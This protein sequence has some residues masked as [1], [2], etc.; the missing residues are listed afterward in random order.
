MIDSRFDGV[1][2]RVSGGCSIQKG[3]T[4]TTELLEAETSPAA[5]TLPLDAPDVSAQAD[6]ETLRAASSASPAL[7]KQ[8]AEVPA[9]GS[10]LMMLILLAAGG[11]FAGMICCSLFA[12]LLCLV[13]VADVCLLILVMK[14]GL[15]GPVIDALS[16]HTQILYAFGCSLRGSKGA[17]YRMLLQRTDAPRLFEA[18]ENLCEKAS[19]RFPQAVYL[20]SG[21]NAWVDSAGL[22]RKNR[23]TRL[24][25]GLDLL[26]G[27]SEPETVA[28]LAHE[29]AHAQRVQWGL[30]HLTC[31][32][33]S[34]IAVLAAHLM[35]L[36]IELR[37]DG[38]RS[39]V[40]CYAFRMTNHL[41]CLT[42]RLLA[43]S[44]RQD[45]YEADR[46]A[47]EMAGLVH[48]RSGL[49]KLRVV[50]SNSCRL[51]W[52]ERL[53]RLETPSGFTPWLIGQLRTDAPA[54][55]INRPEE[56]IDPYATHP[57]NQSRLDALPE[58]LEIPSLDDSL[59]LNLLN[60]PEDLANRLA[61]EFRRIAEKEELRDTKGMPRV[62]YQL[63]RSGAIGKLRAI[64]IVLLSMGI[65]G[66][67][68]MAWMSAFTAG[69][70]FITIGL[71]LTGAVM[72][73]SESSEDVLQLR[74]PSFEALCK[75]KPL[76]G[77]ALNEQVEQMESELLAGIDGTDSTEAQAWKLVEASRDALADC[78]YARGWI[79]ASIALRV[80]SDSTDAKTCLA[81]A[82]A[83]LG[84]RDQ[85]RA[86]LNQL[87]RTANIFQDTSTTWGFAWASMLLED[88]KRAEALLGHPLKSNA[89]HPT[90][91][92]L[93]AVAQSNRGKSWSAL[94]QARRATGLLPGETEPLKKLAF[95]L[96]E[97]GSVTE[98]ASK[99]NTLV[100]LAPSDPTVRM[101]I[102]HKELLLQDP[103][104]IEE[105]EQECRQRDPSPMLLI[106]MS[107][108]YAAARHQ[109][110][111]E[112]LLE[113]A[114]M[115]GHY[116]E[117]LMGLAQMKQSRGDENG[118]RRLLLEAL[119]LSVPAGEDSLGVCA[120]F[121][122]ILV[123]LLSLQTPLSGC[124]VWRGTLSLAASPDCLRGLQVNIYAKDL[125]EAA[126]QF[127]IILDALRP[128]MPPL[129]NDVMQI[130]RFPDK[131]QPTY[132]LPVGVELAA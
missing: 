119:N 57:S 132:P 99:L 92:L 42:T 112:I 14:L 52:P 56:P 13:L 126:R 23:R 24:G 101:M 2:K 36:E 124:R 72:H 106:R 87:S 38:N 100:A 20:E 95:L 58:T 67:L 61:K 78:N 105:A 93:L 37:R 16:A 29:I 123:R 122:G 131:H 63:R 75:A 70:V 15:A 107:I 40:A 43:R 115:L 12:I 26:A 89:D 50:A 114:R 41:A 17:D 66:L 7:P 18:L 94:E 21:V 47:A 79:A 81:I 108:L 77:K 49:K 68:G 90:L 5:E 118:A 10:T 55:R 1:R 35:Q 121:G 64:G 48:V 9:Q 102:L 34:R 76:A 53:A 84:N 25:V 33:R 109:D 44:S 96:L 116:P 98:A 22:F 97:N 62:V 31:W 117:A 51:T 28:V 71:V 54:D 86:V 125:A 80:L 129:L 32:G 30:K 88:W 120:L 74:F 82:A 110:R 113:E 45:E 128:G 60:N 27:Y 11:V 83:G 4:M 39:I 103:Q 104:R 69:W 8:D 85:S 127:K 130:E 46:G 73:F 91:L 19:V 59:G 6:E 111:A 3:L 65:L